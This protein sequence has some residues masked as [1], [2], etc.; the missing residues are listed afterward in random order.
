[1][2]GEKYVQRTPKSKKLFEEARK[3]L[4]SRV[5]YAI[6][7]FEPYPFYV[8]RAEGQKIWDIDE[9]VKV[10]KEFVDKVG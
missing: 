2:F 8:S 7:F 6:R 3:Y 9:L 4:P 5:S 10:T 1:M